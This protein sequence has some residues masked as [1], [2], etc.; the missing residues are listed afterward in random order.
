MIDRHRGNV[1]SRPPRRKRLDTAAEYARAL[2]HMM[3]DTEV[4]FEPITDSRMAEFDPAKKIKASWGQLYDYEQLME[5]AIVH[6]SRHR[7]QI[8]RFKE[9][10]RG[11][12]RSDAG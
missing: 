5:H 6:V 3:D 1:E 10:L 9:I 4:L 7:R 8:Q 2:D 12:H 11:G